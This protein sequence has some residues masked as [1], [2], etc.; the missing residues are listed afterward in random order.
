MI[1]KITSLAFIVFLAN[2]ACSNL[3]VSSLSRGDADE[4]DDDLSLPANTTGSFLTSCDVASGQFTCD[5]SYKDQIIQFGTATYPYEPDYI[6][7]QSKNL[8]E[9]TPESLEDGGVFSYDATSV[10]EGD[11]NATF[12]FN[13]IDIEYYMKSNFG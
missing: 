4:F 7:Y 2:V 11:V 8:F 5:V 1:L 10:P 6:V 12:V 9:D 13:P 3:G